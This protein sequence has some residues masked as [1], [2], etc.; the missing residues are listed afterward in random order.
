MMHTLKTLLLSMSI[1]MAAV[2][3]FGQDTIRVRVMTYNMRFGERAS[4]DEFAAFIKEQSPDFVA[5][6]EVD[7]RN[8]RDATPWQNGRDFIA[9]LAMQTGMFGLYG[10]TINLKG[11]Y[12][13]V[14]ILSRYPY[15][16]VKKTLLPN[17]RNN[18]QRVVLEG[19]FELPHDTVTFACSH[20]DY[21]YPDV[22][23]RQA[24]FLCNHFS[25]HATPVIVAGDFN[26]TPESEA[27]SKAMLQNWLN[28]T[29]GTPTYPADKPVSKLDYIFTD[30]RNDW[31][32]ENTETINVGLSDHLPI[33]SDLIYTTNQ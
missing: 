7:C 30:T 4:L 28:A 1:L 5:L 17:P 2:T 13:G 29:N 20:L 15:I 26:S 10:K 16:D 23:T 21:E 11:G 22:I 27:I 8:L 18:E 6:Q 12:Y 14:G 25:N 32:I 3:V 9:E 24:F 33:I 19:T 31:K